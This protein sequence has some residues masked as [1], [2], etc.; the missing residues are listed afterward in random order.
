MNNNI[1]GSTSH[2]Q[3]HCA[4]NPDLSTLNFGRNKDGTTPGQALN[5]RANAVSRANTGGDHVDL[6]HCIE[7]SGPVPLPDCRAAQLFDGIKS[8][9]RLARD[10]QRLAKESPRDKDFWQAETDRHCERAAWYLERRKRILS[11]R[12][13]DEPE[14]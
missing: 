7:N 4:T 6:L 12:Q 13:T 2:H 10:C 1:G 5:A 11:E 3:A 14:V 9:L 8:A